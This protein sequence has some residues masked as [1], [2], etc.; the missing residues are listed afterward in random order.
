MNR[1]LP[2]KINQKAIKNLQELL[3]DNQAYNDLLATFF[4]ETPLII[5][6]IQSAISSKQPEI[7]QRQAHSLKTNCKTFGAV[8][9]T[10]LCK[11]VEHKS[12]T[13]NYDGINDLV[14][15]IKTEYKQ[16]KAALTILN[17]A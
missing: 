5:K 1:N 3:G 14:K 6:D 11:Q 4:S 16:V 9:L 2:T 10:E 7:I 13:E 12:S 8:K 17:N 15:S